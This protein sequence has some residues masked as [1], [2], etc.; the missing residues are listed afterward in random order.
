MCRSSFLKEPR[1]VGK[2]IGAAGGRPRE[3]IIL[4]RFVNEANL[5]RKTKHF[6]S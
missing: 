2:R 4:A 6:S 5:A 1:G 3:L